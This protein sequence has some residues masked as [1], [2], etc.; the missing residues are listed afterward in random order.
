MAYKQWIDGEV[1]YGADINSNCQKAYYLSALSSTVAYGAASVASTATLVIA[2]NAV[3]NNV[4]IRNMGT[5]SVFIGSTSGVT[6]ITG[7]ELRSYECIVTKDPGD[8]YAI[9]ASGTQDVRYLE[10]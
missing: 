10:V 4:I 9:C 6:T 7:F 3:R 5:T 8:V 2:A 1:L